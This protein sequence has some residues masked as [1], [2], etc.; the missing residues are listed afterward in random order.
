VRLLLFS[1]VLLVLVQTAYAASTDETA[2]WDQLQN[3]ID[4]ARARNVSTKD[5][6]DEYI[7]QE[8][9]QNIN[10]TRVQYVF[11]AA[12]IVLFLSVIAY[13]PKKIKAMKRRR[14][15]KR[16]ENFLDQCFKQG[17][18]EKKIREYFTAMGYKSTYVDHIFKHYY[19][20]KKTDMSYLK[21]RKYRKYII[22]KLKLMIPV[23]EI[24]ERLKKKG[25]PQ[26][27]IDFLYQSI[28]FDNAEKH[29]EHKSSNHFRTW[30][31]IKR[32]ARRIVLFDSIKRG[33]EKKLSSTQIR[34]ILVL[35]GF[36]E[37]HVTDAL[38]RYD[39]H[40]GIGPMQKLSYVLFED[41]FIKFGSF[42][43]KRL[44]K[45]ILEKNP[46]GK[47]GLDDAYSDFVRAGIRQEDAQKIL[48]QYKGTWN[49]KSK[50]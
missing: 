9:K 42:Q 38:A 29:S 20:S 43:R 33:K 16:Y 31:G 26:K 46:P 32:R 15:H 18:G 27:D 3:M 14:R 10:E 13:A 8:S 34:D 11:I 47:H 22:R 45:E 37:L 48:R 23:E 2:Y 39:V 50:F 1:V 19:L 49:K 41:H 25:L 6:M 4:E 44:I 12:G 21:Q 30:R 5:L 28:S 24:L 36:N 7:Q 40:E 17:L 35:A